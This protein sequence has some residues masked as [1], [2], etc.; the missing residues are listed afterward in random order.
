M[1]HLDWTLQFGLCSGHWRLAGARN[2]GSLE[3]HPRPGQEVLLTEPMRYGL[4]ASPSRWES[5]IWKASAVERRVGITTYW[6]E[7]AAA[8]RA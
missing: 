7:R 4:P 1:H 8:G 5:T 3:A 2:V 6:W